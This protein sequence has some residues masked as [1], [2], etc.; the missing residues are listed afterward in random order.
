MAILVAGGTL[1]ERRANA[2]AQPQIDDA[3]R[4][5]SGIELVNV[6]A[7][8]SDSGGRFVP[9]LRREDFIVYE[10]D[11][12]QTVTHFSAERV[13]VSLG[14][15]V[16]TSGSMAGEKILAA[17]KA[18]GRFLGDLL[19]PQDDLF[20]YR[21]S[22]DPVLMQDWTAD[23]DLL[24]RAIGRLAANGGTALYDAVAEAVPLAA[25]G[26]HRKKAL[27]VISDGND[28]SSDVEVP[29]LK[30]RIRES[31]VLVYAIGIDATGQPR[32]NPVPRTRPRPWPVPVP[33]P[34]GRGGQWPPQPIP[35]IG[36]PGGGF[37]TG[38]R[39][40]E[41]VN[42]LALRALTDDSGGRTEI[43]RSAHDLDPATAG[44]ADELSRQ[45]YLG[46][47]TSGVKDGR[48][49]Q[50]RVEVRNGK[51]RVRARRGYFAN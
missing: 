50:I 33:F 36:D 32:A 34:R 41:R 46:Y 9:G 5:S 13:P 29:E 14:V 48:W 44:I 51:Y 23:R 20:L 35:P 3:F 21:F 43:I 26:Q 19:D 40:D 10:D 42:A 28:T 8:V 4:F 7:T 6:T 38:A 2:Q 12:V 45:Y 47:P 31:E 25:H 22:D 37:P 39:I 15:V 27:V 16:D 49:R 1:Q 18:L 24:A 30:R 11:Q 17:R